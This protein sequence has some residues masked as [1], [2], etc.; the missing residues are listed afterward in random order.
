MELRMN[1]RIVVRRFIAGFAAMST[2]PIF[3]GM[4]IRFADVGNTLHPRRG[5]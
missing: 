5:D 4:R 3:W 1:A 2:T